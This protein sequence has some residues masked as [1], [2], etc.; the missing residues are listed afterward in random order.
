VAD[1]P[2]TTLHPVL[3]I[4]VVGDRDLVFADL[5]G[6]VEGAHQ[7]AGLGDRFL[8]HIARTRVLLHLVDALGG[9]E[10]AVR[11]YQAVRE[12]L[13]LAG[14]R[15][16]QLPS[17][18]VLSRADLVDE[19]EAIGAELAQVCG[20]PVPVLSAATGR[21]VADVLGRLAVLV[22]TARGEEAEG[23][24]RPSP[25]QGCRAPVRRAP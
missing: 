6:L 19:P 18:V 9:A 8:R 12:E 16:E 7:G 24:G 3:G 10:K 22:E 17:L 13:R 15:L 25:V 4:G 2:F 20:G 11:R 14:L 1:Y 23:G 21:G 5:P